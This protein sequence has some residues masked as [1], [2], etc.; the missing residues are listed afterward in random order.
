MAGN[1]GE[2]RGM[3]ENGWEWC[4]MSRKVRE[5]VGTVGNGREWL[6]MVWNGWEWWGIGRKG[7]ELVER[8]GI[9]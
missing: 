4:R 2:F 9:G 5:W 1:G 3:V 8:M 7:G 6:G